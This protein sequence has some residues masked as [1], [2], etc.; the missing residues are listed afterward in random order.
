MCTPVGH[1]L[2]GGI[3]LLLVERDSSWFKKPLNWAILT[4]VAFFPD[5]D[6]ILDV[7]FQPDD[8]F[9]HSYSHSIGAA[10][11]FT[12]LFALIIMLRASKIGQN[13][14]NDVKPDRLLSLTWQGFLV[15][16]L[17][18]LVADFF[19][20]DGSPP[21]GGRYLFPI[22]WDYIY[23]PHVLFRPAYKGTFDQTVSIDN[24][25][26]IIGEILIL[27]PILLLVMVYK[28]YNKSYNKRLYSTIA[29]IVYI[30]YVV[31]LMDTFPFLFPFTHG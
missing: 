18:H 17:S 30:L 22:Y 2:A 21:L 7:I 25:L 9:H 16:Y 27:G 12:F 8:P 20:H 13:R 31:M 29:I 6:I 15:I 11:G 10:L 1:A 19:T 23:F 14:V 4:V 24:I 3:G 26:S 5:L 28:D